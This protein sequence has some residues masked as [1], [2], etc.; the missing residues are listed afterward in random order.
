MTSSRKQCFM[1]VTMDVQIV[2]TM[3]VGTIA[4]AILNGVVD[5]IMELIAQVRI[6]SLAIFILV[7]CSI[8]FKV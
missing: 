6:F 7:F 8:L 2:S 3:T 1:I 5:L 4:H